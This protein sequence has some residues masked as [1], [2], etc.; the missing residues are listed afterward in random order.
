MQNKDEANTRLIFGEQN[1]LPPITT[2]SLLTKP[3]KSG[4]GKPP[5][6][7]RQR[8]SQELRSLPS[9]PGHWR[10]RRGRLLVRLKIRGKSE[11]AQTT[12]IEALKVDLSVPHTRGKVRCSQSV[13]LGKH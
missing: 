10:N 3:V 13:S 12:S 6:K 8:I 4:T 7:E 11:E 5:E 2:T 9:F 1:K